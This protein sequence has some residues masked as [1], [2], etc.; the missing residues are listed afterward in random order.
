MSRVL[1]LIGFLSTISCVIAEKTEDKTSKAVL[2]YAVTVNESGQSRLLNGTDLGK[3][4]CSVTPTVTYCPD[5]Q[6][7]CSTTT[8]CATWLKCCGGG[9]YCCNSAT[10]SGATLV[11]IFA[12]LLLYFG[13]SKV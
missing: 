2:A 1:F 4:I 10:T 9:R 12:A 5:G 8:C 11:L 6:K 13:T 7:C 3:Q